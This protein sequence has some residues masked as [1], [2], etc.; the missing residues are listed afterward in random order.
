[1]LD[2]FSQGRPVLRLRQVVH[3]TL[4]GFWPVVTFALE[5]KI[6]IKAIFNTFIIIQ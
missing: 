5:M 6:N 4:D 2:R 3:I 1:M